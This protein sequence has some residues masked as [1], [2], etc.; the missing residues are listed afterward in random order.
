MFAN[1]SLRKLEVHICSSDHATSDQ[2]EFFRNSETEISE[3]QK[4]KTN[5]TTRYLNSSKL[6]FYTLAEFRFN[7]ESRVH[8]VKLN[9]ISESRFMVSAIRVRQNSYLLCNVLNTIASNSI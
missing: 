4:A 7:S 6:F 2:L 3:I 1:C 9:F 5:L 8:T